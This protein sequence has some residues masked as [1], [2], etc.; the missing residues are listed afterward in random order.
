[1]R[2]K[3]RPFEPYPISFKEIYKK[4]IWGGKGMGRVL[5]KRGCESK[6][7]ESCEIIWQDKDISRVTNGPLRGWTLD[8]LINEFAE[9]VLGKEHAMRFRD[10]FPLAIK[11]LNPKDPI[12]LQV[13]PSDE[14][15]S[16]FEMGKRGKMEMWYIVY[17]P[18]TARVMRGVLPGTTKAEFKEHIKGRTL[19]RCLNIM[20]V[21]E[22]DI[23]FIPPGTVHS[24]Y[25]DLIILEIQQNSDT[26]YR[27]YDWDRKDFNGKPR[28]LHLDKALE[29]L[30]LYTMGVSK[31]R[32]IRLP[33]YPYKRKLLIRCEKFT[34]E[35][36][37]F[38]NT[39][40]KQK[41]PYDRFEILTVVQGKG[42][43]QY[44]QK[45]K[46]PFLKGDTFLIP[47]SLVEYNIRSSGICKIICSYVE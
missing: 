9:G 7:G 6:T 24:A 10:Y 47:A 42:V 8:R 31:Y 17:S 43:I 2:D 26:T 34:T 14:F 1:M 27:I 39:T 46:Q 5:K 16:R 4:K 25:G 41:N 23:I 44:S 33:G 37:E 28:D 32:P 45:G 22:G 19:E 20:E 12:S 29:V 40:I 11:F 30:D 36:I 13:H 38:T 15:A 35:S 21:K 18:K 3:M